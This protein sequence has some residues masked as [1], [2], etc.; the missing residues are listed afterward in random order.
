MKFGWSVAALSALCFFASCAASQKAEI[1]SLV[2]QDP[3]APYTI[4]SLDQIARTPNE[5]LSSDVQ[6][7]CI[8][9]QTNE[10]FFVPVYTPFSQE[11][12]ISM[13]IWPVNTRLW[14]ASEN[15]KKLVRTVYIR[16]DNPL[17]NHIL[18]LNQY[19]V[20]RVKGSVKSHFEGI[21]W[22][23]VYLVETTGQ[24]AITPKAFSLFLNGE[25]ALQNN[26]LAEA[27]RF[28]ELSAMAGL[29][30]QPKKEAYVNLAR[31]LTAVKTPQQVEEGRWYYARARELDP[32]DEMLAMESA[33]AEGAIADVGAPTPTPEEPRTPA[34]ADN[35]LKEENAQLKD[36]LS[37][38]DADLSA[39]DAEIARLTEQLKQVPG[40]E[41]MDK[42]RQ[43][44]DEREKAAMEFKSAKEQVEADM[45]K[46]MDECAAKT[47]EIEKQI[48]DLKGQVDGKA[49]EVEDA[50]RASEEQAAKI[51]ELQ[52]RI[53]DMGKA[54]G[55][56]ELAAVQKQLEE[57]KTAKD[58][59]DKQ[60]ADL[61]TKVGELEIKIKDMSTQT[62]GT[63]E[64][65]KAL[66]TELAKAK[67]DAAKGKEGVREEVAKEYEE[68]ISK[69]RE[70]IKNQR[71]E[72]EEL[73]KKLQEKKE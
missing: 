27:I 1:S 21:P 59:A 24:M 45:K 8:F 30:A 46:H 2:R 34:P 18:R 19:Q 68:V 13:S 63:D 38:K 47:A 58:A 64:K 29:P 57:A 32:K 56:E 52:K 51:A 12:H 61:T 11:R 9:N 25:Q 4:V 6:F 28:Y 31:A 53:E 72:I 17:V 41:E 16:K 60:V 36:Q 23:E 33:K 20:M 15:N 10:D 67:E 62:G 66:E 44:R 42:L 69:L 65:V 7:D 14:D 37:K 73:Y 35:A 26:K 55:A 71:A 5:F 48:G 54:P 22:I 70:T 39:K 3:S 40:G 50:K 49:K 43:E